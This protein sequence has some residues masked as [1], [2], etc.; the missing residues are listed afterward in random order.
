MSKK[1]F[2][3]PFHVKRLD[4]SIMPKGLSGAYVSC[5]VHTENYKKAVQKALKQLLSDGLHPEE[6]LEPILESLIGDLYEYI[7]SAWNT[8]VQQS[9]NRE[10]VEHLLRIGRVVYGPFASYK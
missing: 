4:S 9:F 7:G 3:V 6:I 5:F 8:D 10:E 1:V 2:I